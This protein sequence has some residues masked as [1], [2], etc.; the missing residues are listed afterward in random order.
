MLTFVYPCPATG[1]TLDPGELMVLA[2]SILTPP[3]RAVRYGRAQRTVFFK[4]EEPVVNKGG[5]S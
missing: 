2:T 3:E 1:G 5:D 4:L